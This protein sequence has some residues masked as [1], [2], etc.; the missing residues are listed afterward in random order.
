LKGLNNPLT[1]GGGLATIPKRF[2]VARA[3]LR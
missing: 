1:P 2:G 3:L